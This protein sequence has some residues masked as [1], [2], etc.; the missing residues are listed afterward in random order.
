[1]VTTQQTSKMPAKVPEELADFGT[2]PFT[3]PA[4][5]ENEQPVWCVACGRARS[6]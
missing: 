5:M 6:T 4:L 3:L 2:R 1:M